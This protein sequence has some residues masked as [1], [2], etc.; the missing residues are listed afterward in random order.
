M[1]RILRIFALMSVVGLGL[2]LVGFFLYH[3]A[4]LPVIGAGFGAVL[5]TYLLVAAVMA[6]AAWI[7]GSAASVVGVIAA[8]ASVQRRQRGWAI[9]LIGAVVL[10]YSYGLFL[11]FVPALARPFFPSPFIAAVDGPLLGVVTVLPIALLV[12]VYSFLPTPKVVAAPG[13]VT[14]A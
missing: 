5:G 12:L 4:A 1:T 9:A 6:V 2:Y 7:G 8:V 13:E 3:A 11:S 10:H 14:Q